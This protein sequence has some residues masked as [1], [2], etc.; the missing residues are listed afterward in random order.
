MNEMR[1]DIAAVV[2]TGNVYGIGGTCTGREVPVDTMERI[3]VLD[4]LSFSSKKRSGEQTPWK[5]LKCRLSEERFACSA[6]V[7]HNRYIVVAGGYGWTTEQVL[8]SVEIIDTNQENQP[9][10]FPGP[11]LNVPRHGVGLAAIGSCVYLA[12]NPDEF[13]DFKNFEYLELSGSC[14]EGTNETATSV[15]PPSLSWTLMEDWSFNRHHSLHAV[16]RVGSCLVIRGGSLTSPVDVVDMKRNKVWNNVP[17]MTVARKGHS[18]VA[19]STGTVCIS[20]EGENSCEQ[21]SLMDKNTVV[22]THL[23][24]MKFCQQI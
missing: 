1:A 7:I 3:N 8:S 16:V 14:R 9:H 19:L 21:L 11:Q 20:G 12:G 10:V 5:A 15:F 18:S 2:C 13:I 17:Q 22:Y 4:L 23:L 6:V 24:G